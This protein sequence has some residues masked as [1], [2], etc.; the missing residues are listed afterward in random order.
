MT[1]VARDA[2]VSRENLYRMTCE[3]GNP[4]RSS[5][6]AILRA[7]GLDYEIVP[8]ASKTESADLEVRR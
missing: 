4:K 8:L 3:T 7:L 6:E 5:F 1:K 2:G